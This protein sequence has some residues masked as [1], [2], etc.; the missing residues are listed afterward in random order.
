MKSFADVDVA[1]AGD[2][3]LI[4]QSRFQVCPLTRADLRQFFGPEGIPQGLSSKIF[5]GRVLFKR[6]SGSHVHEPKAPRIIVNNPDSIREM[7][8]NMIM[9]AVVRSRV[10]EPSQSFDCS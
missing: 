2:N 10:M 9:G 3:T 1:E 5:E 7:K 6:E 8:H 4:Q